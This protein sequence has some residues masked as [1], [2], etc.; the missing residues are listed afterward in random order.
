MR[1]RALHDLGYKE[2]P[3]A[4]IDPDTPAEKL[5]AYTILDNSNFGQWDWDLIANQ[6]DIA[7]LGD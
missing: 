7:D 2:V 6:W 3:C 1:R 5:R 4:V